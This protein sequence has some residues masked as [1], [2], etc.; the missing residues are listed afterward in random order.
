MKT[1]IGVSILAAPGE[2]LADCLDSIHNKVDEIAVFTWDVEQTET[3]NRFGAK[4]V[5]VDPASYVEP[6]RQEMQN[7]VSSEWVLILDPDEVVEENGIDF[8]RKMIH[9]GSCDIVGYWIPYRMMFFGSELS[10]S[11]PNIKQMRLFRRD[12]VSYSSS[13]HNIPS[14]IDGV[15]GYFDDADPGIEHRFVRDFQQRFERHL[16]WAKIEAEELY[17]SGKFI[18]D[19]IS[20]LESGIEEFQIYTVERKGLRDGCNGLVNALMHSWKRIAMMCFLWE[21][22]G[23]NNLPIK[24]ASSLEQKVIDLGSVDIF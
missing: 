11:F 10:N 23:S 1:T 12:R 14:P 5:A 17:R 15:Y 7:T 9:L 4:V 2:P 20:I 24:D 13:I 18:N 16:K 8:F 3:A 6:L 19:P 21:L 22:H